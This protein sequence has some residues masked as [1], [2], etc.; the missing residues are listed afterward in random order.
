L[1]STLGLRMSANGDLMEKFHG[2]SLT[3]LAYHE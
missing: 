3:K 2:S 1:S